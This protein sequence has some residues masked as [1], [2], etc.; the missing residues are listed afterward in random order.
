[1]LRLAALLPDTPSFLETRGM[2]LDGCCELLGAEDGDGGPSF[3]ARG[4]YPEEKLVSVVGFPAGE[5]VT[6]AVSRNA[7]SGAVVA[8]PENA[9]LVAQTLP[10]WEMRTAILHRLGEGGL[11]P[12]PEGDVRLLS[13][14]EGLHVL[15]RGLRAEL[16]AELEG[17]LR[18]HTPL[19]AAFVGEAP[20]SFC[21]V[22]SETEG[23]WDVSIDTLAAYR[24]RG[25]AARCAAFMVRHMRET[26]GKE[27]VWGALE[28]NAASMNLAASLG[29]VSVDRY[30]VLEPSGRV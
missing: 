13:G 5:W 18:G 6:E 29:F 26:A 4:L 3:V 10:G 30:S 24:R 23:L 28:T 14:P 19:A 27:P 9:A 7:G 17:V 12:T 11:A 25:Y 15:P 2:L 8:M 20:V 22:A 16:R 21:Y 1:M